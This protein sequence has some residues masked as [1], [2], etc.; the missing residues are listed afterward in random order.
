V[1]S[2]VAILRRHFAGGRAP[3]TTERALHCLSSLVH[4][5][6]HTATAIARATAAGYEDAVRSLLTAQ[7]QRPLR[8]ASPG[9]LTPAGMLTAKLTLDLL[10]ATA[11]NA[12]AAAVAAAQEEELAEAEDQ[13]AA[14]A[15]TMTE[16][17]P[18]PSLAAAARRNGID[19]VPARMVSVAALSTSRSR[20][21]PRSGTTAHYR[22]R[23]AI[24]SV[25]AAANARRQQAD[26]VASNDRTLERSS[27]PGPLVVTLQCL[28]TFVAA[29]V[30]IGRAS[31]RERVFA[32]V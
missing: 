16:F 29:H 18:R 5:P 17:T 22:S 13:A 21:L 12:E 19:G 31:C 30:E 28:L 27:V 3:G 9:G 4:R 2:L 14:A 1:E 15:T 24:A 6:E 26:H 20:S 25:A 10:A 11:A 8:A 7:Q 32:T 23:R